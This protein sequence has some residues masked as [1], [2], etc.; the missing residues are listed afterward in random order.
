VKPWGT[1]VA[2]VMGHVDLSMKARGLHDEDV[3][4]E[5]ERR[6]QVLVDTG[7]LHADGDL[8]EWRASEVRTPSG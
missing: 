1:K 7:R 4:D 2:A 8:S 5:V 3:F 6:L